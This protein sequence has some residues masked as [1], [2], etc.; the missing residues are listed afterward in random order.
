MLYTSAMDYARKL[1]FSSYVH[2]PPINKMIQYCF[3]R[4]ILSSVGEVI[5]FKH[6]CYISALVHIRMM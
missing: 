5:F 2:V 1:N 6:G 3:A 4:V